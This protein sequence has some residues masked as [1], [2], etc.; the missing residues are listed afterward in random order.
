MLNDPF[1]SRPDDRRVVRVNTDGTEGPVPWPEVKVGDILRGEDGKKRRVVTEPLMLGEIA[2]GR[3][4]FVDGKR[5][6]DIWYEAITHGRWTFF[7]SLVPPTSPFG[8]RAGTEVESEL[9]HHKIEAVT[10][11]EVPEETKVAAD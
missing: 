8:K 9:G 6:R 3:F 7:H 5:S 2:T 10:F 11:V 1:S 4:H